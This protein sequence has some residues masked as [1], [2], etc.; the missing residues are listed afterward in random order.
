MN[1]TLIR[2]AYMQD[3]TLG[4]MVDTDTGHFI[5]AT[6]EEPWKENKRQISCIPEG[7]YVCKPHSG[8]KFQN[9]WEVTNVP[10]RS[11]VLIHAGNT[12]DDIEGCILV[13]MEHGILN[14]K[15][16]VIRSREALLKIRKDNLGKTFNL[17]IKGK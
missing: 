6:L 9:V 12:T 8:N 3:V 14:H 11:A 7:T 15:E 2:H 17:T 1:I 4:V 10:N 13:G 16:A 5:C